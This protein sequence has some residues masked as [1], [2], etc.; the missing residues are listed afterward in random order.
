MGGAQTAE[1]PALHTAGE[2]LTRAGARHINELARDEVVG[3][4]F[5]TDRDQRVLGHAELGELLLGLDLGDR[6]AAALGLRHV[7]YLGL[8]DADLEGDVAI[9]L[10]RAVCHN[11]A[12]INLE[13]SD[14]HMLASVCKDAG[15]A[16]LPCDDA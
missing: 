8:A 11:L 14:G 12:L 7:L 13:H 16:D 1:V 5:G 10:S 4:D 6:E 9:L 15:H 3:R 2:P